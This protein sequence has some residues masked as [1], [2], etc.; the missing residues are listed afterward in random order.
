MKPRSQPRPQARKR[1]RPQRETIHIDPE[2][3][4][5]IPPP[6]AGDLAQLERSLLAVGC[7]DALVVWRGK[8]ILLDG[9]T[10]LPLCRKHSLPFRTVMIDL[11]D[12]AAARAYVIANQLSRRNLTREAAAFLRGHRYLQLRHQGQSTSG[13][14]DPK[15]ASEQLAREY[16]VGEKTIRRD[17]RFARDVDAIV[18]N[19]GPESRP[20]ILGRDCGLTR[21][22]VQRLARMPPAEQQH[23]VRELMRTGKLPR[24]PG[25]AGATFTLPTE[26]GALIRRLVARL[27]REAAVVVHRLLGVALAPVNG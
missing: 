22:A 23:L 20:W 19:C 13:H 17:A 8:G 27:G 12:R 16:G 26:P 18:A 14:N 6:A 4:A 3:A 1:P 11:P 25:A 15:R 2:F 5:L 10:R 24:P 9:H 21:G 7:R